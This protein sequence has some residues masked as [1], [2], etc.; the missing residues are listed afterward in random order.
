M[1]RLY[2]VSAPSGAGKSSLLTALIDQVQDVKISVSTTTRASRPGEINGKHY[3]FVTIEQ[4][5]SMIQQDEFYEH[6]KVFGNYYGT[7]KSWVAE[8]LESGVDV[9]LE[10]DWQGAQQMREVTKDIITIFIVPP[11]IE[12][13]HNRLVGRGQDSDE[14]IEKRMSEAR[15]EISHYDEYDYVVINDEFDHAVNQIKSIFASNRLTLETQQRTNKALLEA[16]L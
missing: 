11:S 6:A 2:I 7:S 15:S 4:F 16:L 8:Q 13:L 12:A 10:I 5:E 3:N 14:I 9:I 1:G